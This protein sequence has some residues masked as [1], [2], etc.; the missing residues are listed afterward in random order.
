MRHG[1]PIQR[2]L[3]ACDPTPSALGQLGALASKPAVGDPFRPSQLR[4]VHVS[5]RASADRLAA[6]S[7]FYGEELGLDPVTR[8]AE[9]VR[10]AIGETVLEYVA[11]P[12]EPFYHFALLVPGDR[13]AAALEGARARAEL[14][15][16]PRS[17][18]MVF[19]FDAWNAQACY[20]HDP[21]GNIVE[22][23]AHHGIGE[24]VVRGDFRAGELLGISELGLVG[25][26]VAMAEL[27]SSKL[28]PRALRDTPRPVPAPVR[29]MPGACPGVA[30]WE[31]VTAKARLSGELRRSSGGM[32]TIRA[33]IVVA[34]VLLAGLVAVASRSPLGS[35]R[36]PGLLTGG[37]SPVDIPSPWI[38]ALMVIGSGVALFTVGYS[39][40]LGRGRRTRGRKRGYGFA[41]GLQLVVLVA[42]VALA[43]ALFA[44]RSH[45]GRPAGLPHAGHGGAHAAR[46]GGSAL[47]FL[48]WLPIVALSAL[49]LIDVVILAIAFGPS[50]RGSPE[51][52]A[53]EDAVSSAVAASLDALEREPD[54]R[55]A[56]IAA[57]RRMELALSE[58]GLPRRAAE[59]PR[60]YLRRAIGS[61]EVSAASLTTLTGLFERARFSVRSIGPTQRDQAIAALQQMRDE[62]KVDGVATRG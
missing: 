23:I 34:V 40:R 17:D 15:P 4:F 14:L 20:F 61:L 62:L 45:P 46:S 36:S 28:W 33:L 42:A 7:D 51:P 50:R 3:H 22:L 1:E 41:S 44:H 29:F 6:I 19:D 38:L 27:L 31:V 11:G 43:V 60:E 59:S 30:P 57:Y 53:G 8:T 49:V 13:F 2:H 12:G 55:R 24:R 9:A 48:G 54:P 32:N 26:P 58:A 35:G 37:S 39:V 47:A 5:L 16:D 56:V 52:V 21:G 25:D 18:Q 10:F